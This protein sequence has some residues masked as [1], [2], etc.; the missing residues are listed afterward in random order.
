MFMC[1]H[2]LRDTVDYSSS[3][4]NDISVI[5][6]LYDFSSSVEWR[7]LAISQKEMFGKSLCKE[8]TEIYINKNGQKRKFGIFTIF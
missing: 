8:L 6:N 2:F 4:K 1:Y 5:P 7:C 3:L